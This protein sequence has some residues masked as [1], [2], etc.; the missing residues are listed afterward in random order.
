MSVADRCIIFPRTD[1][2]LV[3]P[4]GQ[5]IAVAIKLRAH[6]AS[7]LDPVGKTLT[8]NSDD[9]GNAGPN[10]SFDQISQA[11]AVPFPLAE[12]VDD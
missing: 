3:P 10:R 12:P 9:Y 4:I 6:A 2:G 7:D 5:C 8:G 11:A 1:A